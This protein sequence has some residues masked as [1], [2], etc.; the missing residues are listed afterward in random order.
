[1]GYVYSRVATP[2]C[3]V[4]LGLY[5][6]AMASCDSTLAMS[7]SDDLREEVSYYRAMTRLGRKEHDSAEVA[8]K[9]LTVDFPRG[10]YVNDA[11]RLMSILDRSSEEP[12]I[13]DSYIS[14]ILY[15]FRGK[16]DSAASA[17]ISIAASGNKRVSDIAT[18]ELAELN[19]NRH[20]S[21]TALTLASEMQGKFPESYYLPYALK[22]QADIMCGSVA[23]TEQAKATYRLLLEKYPNY[24]FVA[25]VRRRLKEMDEELRIG[26]TNCT[27]AQFATSDPF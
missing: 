25:E 19:F 26:F 5:D 22:L 2:R 27:S 6:L 10:F 1:M 23:T 14:A 9:K 21:A 11:L 13:L 18:W 12:A 15:R 17:L 3:L 16:D 7:L 24:P 4:G 20:D 8:L